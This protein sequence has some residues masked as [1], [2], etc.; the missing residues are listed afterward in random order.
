MLHKS[1]ESVLLVCQIKRNKKRDSIGS[2]AIG[3][4]F[5]VGSPTSA[6]SNT[7]VLCRESFSVN[8]SKHY[9]NAGF[10]AS[11]FLW[12]LPGYHKHQHCGSFQC[13]IPM[14]LKFLIVSP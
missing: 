14:S 7:A 10:I 5:L 9:L 12:G 1:I 4:M 6:A 8:I 3:G 13:C 11:L 2:I